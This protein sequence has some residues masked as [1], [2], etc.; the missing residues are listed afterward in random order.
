MIFL[1][2]RIKPNRR[3]SMSGLIAFWMLMGWC[4]NEPRGPIPKKPDPIPWWI[5]KILGVIGGVAGGWLFYQVWPPGQEA[6]ITGIYVAATGIGAYVG[7]AF[8]CDVYG[9]IRG[10]SSEMKG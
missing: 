7:S 10:R 2:L 9:L 6:G 4:G 3:N 8:L 5:I 1:S